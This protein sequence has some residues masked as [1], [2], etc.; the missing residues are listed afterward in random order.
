MTNSENQTRERLDVWLKKQYPSYSRTILQQLCS[1]GNVIVNGRTEKSGYKLRGDEKI[2]I[3]R[4]M[5]KNVDSPPEINLPIIYEDN[6]CLVINKPNGILTHSKGAYNPEPTVASV[7]KSMIDANMTGER[8]GIV[9]RLDRGTSGVIICAKTNQ[10]QKWLQK[11]FSMHRVKKIYYA[12]VAGQLHP[13]Q[14]IID[15]PIERHPRYPQRFRVGL[16]G[17]QANTTYKVIKSLK[18]YSLVE[19]QPQTGRTHQLRV[20]LKYLGHPIIGDILYGKQEQGRLYLHAYSL[21]ITLLNRQRKTFV[22]P[23]P[24]EFNDMTQ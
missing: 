11:Q 16:N 15:M 12:L 21:E 14:A 24:D 9:H 22:A 20:H 19:L 18:D 3:L 13:R 8:A 17:K 10:A 5:S 1:D 6:D 7:I 23:L 2:N 4:D